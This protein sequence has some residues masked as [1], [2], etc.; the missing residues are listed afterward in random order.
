M[1]NSEDFERFYF[2]Y[3]TDSLPHGESILSFCNR[4]KVPY[5]VSHHLTVRCISK[6]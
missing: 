5:N 1:Y 6:K 2:Q 3:Q 4:N